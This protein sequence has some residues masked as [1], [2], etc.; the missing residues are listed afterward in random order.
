MNGDWPWMMLEGEC[1]A[2][3]FFCAIMST[4]DN[5]FDLIWFGFDWMRLMRDEGYD[6]NKTN[7]KWTRAGI[8]N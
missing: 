2:G 4:F 7:R 5:E 3:G 1:N 8:K 6:A